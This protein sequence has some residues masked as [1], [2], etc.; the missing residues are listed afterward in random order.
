M[1]LLVGKIPGTKKKTEVCILCQLWIQWC[2]VITL[3]TASLFYPSTCNKYRQSSTFA[4]STFVQPA[5][6]HF[7][8]FHSPIHLLYAADEQTFQAVTQW[9]WLSAKLTAQSLH[10]V[11][12]VVCVHTVVSKQWTTLVTPGLK[13]RNPQWMVAGQGY[14]QIWSRILQVLRRL[15]K[16]KQSH[17]RPGQDLRVPGG[18]GSQISKQSDMEVVRL[19]AL[20]TGCIY[21]LGNIPGTHIRWEAESTPGP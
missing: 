18:W 17:Y 20:H 8:Y 10:G 11:C 14:A 15:L 19:S 3:Y 12:N 9:H 6:S 2:I 4:C 21:T 16:V 7:I 1:I 13:Y 5:L